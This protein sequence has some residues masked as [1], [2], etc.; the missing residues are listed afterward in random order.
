MKL[1]MFDIDGTLTQ[2][3]KID[4]VCFVQALSDLFGFADIDT[5]WATYP[6]ASDSGVLE[7]L[8]QSRL[9]RSPLPAEIS[10]CKTHFFS[11]LTEATAAQPFNSIAGAGGILV[12]LTC[13]PAFGVSLASGAWE[14]SARLKLASAG[15]DA[16]PL[17][18]AFSDDAE[19]RESIM[20]TS[21]ARAVQAHAGASFDSVIYIGDAVWD[22]RASR[23]LGFQFIGIAHEPARVEKLYSGGASHVFPNYLDAR[24]FLSALDA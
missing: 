5:D 13:N 3:C 15:L 17:P 24:A 19:A 9:G 12:A 8:F 2:T 21:L 10:E 16:S 23:N 4:E 7:A 18:A 1:I 14:C 6:H 20:Q 11:L 22:A